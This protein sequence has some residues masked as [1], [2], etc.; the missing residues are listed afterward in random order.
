MAKLNM[1]DVMKLLEG[2]M[3]IKDLAD[4][5]AV[6]YK[7]MQKRIERYR[8]KQH[9]PLKPV[10]SKRQINAHWGLKIKQHVETYPKDSLRDRCNKLQQ[11][12]FPFCY[13]TLNR[14]MKE[15]NLNKHRREYGI[16]FSQQH[17]DQRVCFATRM[18]Q[19]ISEDPDFLKCIIFSD[20]SVFKFQNFDSQKFYYGVN[21]RN[22]MRVRRKQGDRYGTQFWGCF[23]F[24]GLGPIT[25]IRGKLNQFTYCQMMQ[26]HLLPE[27]NAAK[28]L[29]RPFF[30]QDNAP[31]HNAR[32]TRNWFKQKGIVLIDW[33]SCSP[34]LNPIE[35]LW[36]IMKRR[37]G[38]LD[39][40]PNEDAL[41]NITLKLWESIQE[42]DLDMLENLAL[43]F[44]TKLQKCLQLNGDLIN[45]FYL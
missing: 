29:F 42:N 45:K 21:K 8:Q 26:D 40:P 5:E 14:Y 7:C 30:Q 36:A 1:D 41:E 11:Q 43:S 24:Y 38:K 15:N 9:L 27:W 37:L 13:Q 23:S 10:I 44:K 35:D 32:Y 6:T 34:D 33:P 31:C 4:L 28:T 39:F 17:K 12:G 22:D 25:T 3:N 20:E 2:G 19:I 16:V 18:L